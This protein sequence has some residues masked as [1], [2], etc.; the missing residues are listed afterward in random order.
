MDAK[1]HIDKIADLLGGSALPPFLQ[2]LLLTSL[3]NRPVTEIYEKLRLLK[4]YLN[5]QDDI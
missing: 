1:E 3:E 5:E 2:S 4:Q